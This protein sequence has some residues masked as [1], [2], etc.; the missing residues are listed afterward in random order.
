[1]EPSTS[2]TFGA[3]LKELRNRIANGLST[4]G[5]SPIGREEEFAIIQNHIKSCFNDKRGGAIYASGLPGTGKQLKRNSQFS[6]VFRKV[7]D[8]P[9]STWESVDHEQLH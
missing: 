8:H 7:N 4:S 5:V 3:K 1:M 6:N 2:T 9:W